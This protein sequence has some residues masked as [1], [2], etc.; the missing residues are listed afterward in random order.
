MRLKHLRGLQVESPLAAGHAFLS[1]ASGVAVVGDYICVIGD[2]EHHLALFH[3]T[4]IAAGRLLRLLPGDLPRDAKL[5]KAQKP[6]FE[7]LLA[8]PAKNGRTGLRLLALGSGSTDRRNQ[9]FEIEI[10]AMGQLHDMQMINLQNLYADIASRVPE[11]NLEGAVVKGDELL[12]FNRGNISSP[13]TRILATNLS[14]LTKASTPEATVKKLLKLP[15]IDG[16]PLSVTDACLLEDGTILLSA[17]AEATDNSYA[18]GT[19]VG[20]AVILLD[21]QFDIVAIERLN[22]GVKVEG[23]SGRRITV[24]IDMLCVTDADDPDKPAGLYSALWRI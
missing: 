3:R 23:I 11:I 21:D 24:G 12:L 16:I 20:S 7:I 10:D 13:E 22:P 19:L 4:E 1:A 17:V 9:G 15:S 14:N 2:D 18:D 8:L 6:D 5:R